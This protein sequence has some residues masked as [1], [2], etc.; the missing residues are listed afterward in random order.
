MADVDISA[1]AV[2]R[3]IRE[4]QE[5]GFDNAAATLRALRAERADGAD[6]LVALKDWRLSMRG[7]V[8]HSPQEKALLGVI[9][10]I[11]RAGLIAQEP[12]TPFHLTP[13][14]FQEMHNAG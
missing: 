9:E 10:A 11:E 12:R 1:E 14:Q 4:L 3:R 7:Y 13:Q 5:A 8:V 2:E 6:L